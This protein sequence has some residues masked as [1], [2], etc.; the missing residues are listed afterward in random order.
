MGAR[1]P[2]WLPQVS[3]PKPTAS[4][5]SVLSRLTA[6][7]ILLWPTPSA[8]LPLLT[9]CFAAFESSLALCIALEAAAEF[10]ELAEL[11][12]HPHGPT[13]KIRTICWQDSGSP[14]SLVL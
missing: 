4:F 14:V 11:L 9:S 3:Y 5:D 2:Y 7:T 12:R 8:F 1:C 13:P 10:L 6:R